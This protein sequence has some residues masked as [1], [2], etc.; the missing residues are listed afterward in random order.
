V[1]VPHLAP[2][3]LS[4]AVCSHAREG[5][6]GCRRGGGPEACEKRGCCGEK[7]LAGCWE[8]GDFP[9]QEGFFAEEAWTGLTVGMCQAIREH[10]VAA[11]AARAIEVFGETVDYG[12]WRFKDPEEIEELL[13]R[14]SRGGQL[15]APTIH[16]AGESR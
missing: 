8:C 4:C 6:V 12:Y 7:G 13:R 2:C 9:C 16:D 14:R 11:V 3:G 15:S 1:S 5:C 10:G